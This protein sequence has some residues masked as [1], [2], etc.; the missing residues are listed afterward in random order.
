MPLQWAIALWLQPQVLL[1]QPVRPGPCGDFSDPVPLAGAAHAVLPF[2]E[3]LADAG[4]DSEGNHRFCREGLGVR[5]LILAWPKR[6]AVVATT[7]YRLAMLRVL[8]RA[9]TRR[10]S[11]RAG[12][13]GR[14]RR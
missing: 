9:G 13:G 12:S 5:S 10:R 8:V 14:W 7:P 6:W 2:D 11:G 3:L 4:C 1:A